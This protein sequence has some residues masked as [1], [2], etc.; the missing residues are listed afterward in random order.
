MPNKIR[1]VSA[2]EVF[3]IFD[4]DHLI[5]PD[6]GNQYARDLLQKADLQFGGVWAQMLLCL[7][8]V[9]E[10]LLPPHNHREGGGQIE[11]IQASGLTVSAATD[12]LR[13]IMSSYQSSNIVCWR[14]IAY[15]MNLYPSPVFL[16]AGPVISNSDY[17]QLTD[18]DGHLIHLDG[19]HR[20]IAWGLAGKLDPD[21]YDKQQ[22]VEAYVAG[23]PQG[24]QPQ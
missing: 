5:Q 17:Q 4:Q 24:A 16:S 19:L 23:W 13:G 12:K 18:P 3:K 2:E 21:Q 22:A 14:K 15:W 7:E 20:L 11:L 6:N 1:T 10:I 8:D 9:L